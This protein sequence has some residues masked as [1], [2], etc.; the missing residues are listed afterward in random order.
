MR[1]RFMPGDLSLS[2]VA[3]ILQPVL[4]GRLRNLLAVAPPNAPQAPIMSA[5]NLLC[6]CTVVLLLIS[7]FVCR[8]LRCSAPYLLY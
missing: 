1:V 2:A 8:L 6:V 3:G 7:L 5:G 4:P